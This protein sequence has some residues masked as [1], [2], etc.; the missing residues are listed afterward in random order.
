MIRQ[1]G[2]FRGHGHCGS[3]DIMG[4]VMIESHSLGCHRYYASGDI[5]VLVVQKQ[6]STC[7]RL[8]LSLLFISKGHGLKAHDVS[9]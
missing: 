3:G 6:D 9:Y 7:C 2:K 4:L 8:N 1:L 5:M